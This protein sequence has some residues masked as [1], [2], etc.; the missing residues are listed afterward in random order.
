MKK[1]TVLAVVAALAAGVWFAGAGRAADGKEVT[2][3]SIM[4]KI[5]KGK[6]ALHPT[7]KTQLG[8]GDIDWPTVQKETK[9]YFDLALVMVKLKP[10][11]GEAASW[12]KLAKA[13]CGDAKALNA[14]AEKKDKSAAVAAHGKLSKSCKACHDAHR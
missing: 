13:Y 12:E 11:T 4:K 8:S 2:I 10:E 1:L 6:T 3:S 9:E 7:L 5:N 14:A